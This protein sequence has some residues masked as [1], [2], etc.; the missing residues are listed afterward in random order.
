RLVACLGAADGKT[1]WTR[2]FPGEKHGKHQDNSFT[3]GTPTVDGKRLYLSW[4]TPREYL[5][6][7]LD[8]DGK[9]VWRVDLGPFKSGH[10]FGSPPILHDDL[11]IVPNDQDGKSEA[12]ALDAATGKVRWRAA[13]NC[14]AS[15]A[16]PCIWQPKN[17]PAELIFTS[18]ERGIT[19][20][21]PKT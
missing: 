20:L 6:I 21:D 3:S 13:R 5:V 19:S 9:E 8:H 1:I 10:G 12:V 4:A 15:W 14:K 2:E 16:T 18:W 17:A 11:L 7:A